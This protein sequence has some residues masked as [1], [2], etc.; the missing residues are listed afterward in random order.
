MSNKV[1]Q[2][3][4]AERIEHLKLA[5]SSSKAV[6]WDEDKA[7]LRH[8][9]EYGAFRERAVQELLRLFTPAQFG[10]GRGFVITDQGGV[11]TQCDVVIFDRS[12]TPSIVT[13]SHQAFFPV[14]SVVAVCEVKSD[15]DSPSVLMNH[16]EKLAKT[17]ELRE[18]ITSPRPYCRHVNVAFDPEKIPVDQMFTFLICNRLGFKPKPEH[19]AYGEGTAPR[20][21]HNL[22][23]SVEDGL[24][25]Y[26]DVG[27]IPN[28]HYPCSGAQVH[29]V[30]WVTADNSQPEGHVKLF[31][32]MLYNALSMAT[33]LEVDM[34]R[35]LQD[36]VVG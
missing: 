7:C 33:L 4:A 20:F 2:A 28:F 13:D 16:L 1:L 34:A 15:I 21:R 19:L 27:G 3:L 32:S 17:K 22:L 6:F 26:K 30:R 9:G 8:P 18:R 23:L 36:K 31:L 24:F 14:E 25:C 5:F 35:Y 12:I 11:S 10:I 29:D